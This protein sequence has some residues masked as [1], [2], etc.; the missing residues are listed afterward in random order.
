MTDVQNDPDRVLYP[1][2]RTGGRGEFERVSWAEAMRD[3]AARL[4]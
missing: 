2:K 1:L 3:I 4:Q